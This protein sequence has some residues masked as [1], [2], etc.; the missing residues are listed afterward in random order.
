MPEP[1]RTVW[2]VAIRE[3]SN[4]AETQCFVASTKQKAIDWIK[5]QPP[6]AWCKGHGWWAI[7]SSEVDTELGEELV[8]GIDLS[9]YDLQGNELDEQPIPV[10]EDHVIAK[11]KLIISLQS[12][13]QA[14]GVIAK[15]ADHPY[16]DTL[17]NRAIHDID[18]TLADTQ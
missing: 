8:E 17:C 1:V 6:G 18:A 3:T 2:L 4:C 12:A 9:F 7:C 11:N 15:S 5:A 10:T 16:I 14:I 13:K